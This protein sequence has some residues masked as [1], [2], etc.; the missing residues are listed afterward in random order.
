MGR[1]TDA[2]SEPAATLRSGSEQDRGRSGRDFNVRAQARGCR[3]GRSDGEVIGM[4]HMAQ[5]ERGV[6]GPLE[7]QNGDHDNQCEG[8][9][10]P[11]PDGVREQDEGAH[12]EGEW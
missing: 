3:R 12:R 4:R 11:P 7:A 6:E 5:M 8:E 2:G 1:V 10:A 9:S